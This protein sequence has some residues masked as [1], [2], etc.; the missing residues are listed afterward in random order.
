MIRDTYIEVSFSTWATATR[1]CFT[2]LHIPAV[3]LSHPSAVVHLCLDNTFLWRG[4]IGL[5]K[6]VT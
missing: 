6:L 1:C 3:H 4:F 5:L 2:N